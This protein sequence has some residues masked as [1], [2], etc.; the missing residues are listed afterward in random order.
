[1]DAIA[2]LLTILIL[3]VLAVLILLVRF[4]KK[5]QASSGSAEQLDTR[6]RDLQETVDRRLHLQSKEVANHLRSQFASSEKL[7]KDIT[8]ELTEVK[9]TG[10]EM[11]SFTEQLQS[12]EQILKNPQRRGAVGEYVLE[13]VIANV[14]PPDA[15]AVQHTF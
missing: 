4:F 11:L 9:A 5:D 8:R 2:W 10:R 7:I 14:L 3:L 15:Y 1:M 13:Q 12:L 6:L